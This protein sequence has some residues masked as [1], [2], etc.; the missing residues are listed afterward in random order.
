MWNPWATVERRWRRVL[1]YYAVT[2][3]NAKPGYDLSL[4]A[5]G[6]HANGGKVGDLLTAIFSASWLSGI[7]SGAGGIGRQLMDQCIGVRGSIGNDA[8]MSYY[9]HYLG[10]DMGLHISVVDEDFGLDLVLHVETVKAFSQQLELL[11]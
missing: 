10:T 3:L 8:F 4:K 9:Y 1:P 7:G 11:F 2:Q 6:V 5:F